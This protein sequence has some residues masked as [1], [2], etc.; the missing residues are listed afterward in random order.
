MI[1]LTGTNYAIVYSNCVF[2]SAKYYTYGYIRTVNISSNGSIIKNIDNAIFNLTVSTSDVTTFQTITNVYQNIYEIGF[3]VP[4]NPITYPPRGYVGTLRVASNGEIGRTEK[5]TVVDNQISLFSKNCTSY[6]LVF[7]ISD[8][9]IAVVYRGC[10][11][12][13]YIE[14]VNMTKAPYKMW[15]RI[16]L[17][18]L[19][20]YVIT[21]ND[22][23]AFATL[24]TTGGNK[25]LNLSLHNGW[26]YLVLSY[27]HSKMKFYNNVTLNTSVACNFNIKTSA[28]QLIFG[29]FSGTYDEFIIH[30][31]GLSDNIIWTSFNLYVPT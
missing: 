19:N 3:T 24:A 13:G 6:P 23:K 5:N 1:H 18:K 30:N 10:F 8:N 15:T 25:T 9:R 14:T 4:N 11:D 12:D 27:N 29:G 20:S 2:A 28:A 21:A 31:S 26:N 7:N 17:S 22:T 16:I